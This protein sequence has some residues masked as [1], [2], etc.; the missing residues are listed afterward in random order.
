MRSS[1]AP[2]S[3]SLPVL[4]V[5]HPGGTPLAMAIGKSKGINENGARFRYDADTLGGSS[6]SG[7]YDQKLDLVALHHAG[8]PQSSIRARYNQ[9][10]P[11][12]R[13]VESLA[14][15]AAEKFWQ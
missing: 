13:I 5:Q 8:D 12:A 7:V 11:I 3:D 9:G 14:A 6:G 15:K 1:I 4:I 2:V 10:I